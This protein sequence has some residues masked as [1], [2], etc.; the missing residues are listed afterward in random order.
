MMR[1]DT[2]SNWLW[3]LQRASHQGA[4]RWMLSYPYGF[5][6]G[7]GPLSQQDIDANAAHPD[8]VQ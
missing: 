1:P 5:G 4:K 6:F 7:N 2:R 8:I 3:Y